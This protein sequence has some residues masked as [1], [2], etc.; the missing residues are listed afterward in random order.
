VR[1]FVAMIITC[2][3]CGQQNRVPPSKLAAHPH[4]GA[5]KSTLDDYPIA[6]GSAAEFDELVRDSP[7]PIVVDFWAAW[8][9]PCR[10]VAPELER[11]AKE[12]R[13]RALVAKVDTEAL[14]DLASRYDIRG[15]PTMVLF[16]GGREAS[17]V[18]GAMPA[19]Q[20][21]ARLGV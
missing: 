13:G 1:I 14:P 20:I 18:S 17:R 21:A 19:A 10:V 16:S 12:R 7:L 6:V 3:S 11:L 15:I 2:H 4:C 9:G 8:C 5:C